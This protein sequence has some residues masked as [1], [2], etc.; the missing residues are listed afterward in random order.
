VSKFRR[1][2]A[3][4]SWG[5]CLAGPRKTA[6]RAIPLVI[7]F[8]ATL[9]SCAPAPTSPPRTA[10]LGTYVDDGPAWSRDGQRIAFHRRY[11]SS[12]GPPGVYIISRWGGTPRLLFEGDFIW[13]TSMQFSPVG[14]QIACEWGRI[15]SLIDVES[16]ALNY[17]VG[18][19]HAS[20]DPDWSP[21]GNR[22]GCVRPGYSSVAP[23]PPD[24]VGI[25]I[26]DV[27]TEVDRPIH[28]DGEVIRGEGTRWSPEGDFIPS[29]SHR[30]G[31][32][33]SDSR[34][35]GPVEPVTCCLPARTSAVRSTTSN[36]APAVGR[37]PPW[38]S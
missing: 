34:R 20:L 6:S 23:L 9:A 2:G 8:A 13:P 35:S 25:H 10:T 5:T 14:R 30:P 17:P 33:D 38:P 22:L 16:G 36:G 31:G 3:I 7:A 18:T 15:V 29:E 12:Y 11:E 27:R 26:L 32:V 37:A 1:T 21:D 28:Q 4:M 24:S 19:V